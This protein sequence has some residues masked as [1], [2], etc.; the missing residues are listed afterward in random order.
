[1]KN[2]SLYKHANTSISTYLVR[3]ANHHL[4]QHHSA[5]S[6]VAKPTT[7]YQE[8]DASINKQQQAYILLLQTSPTSQNDPLGP[9][10]GGKRPIAR[11]T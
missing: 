9:L 7:F 1:M 6:V 4:P 5:C 2:I 11:K 10:H 3:C 8:S